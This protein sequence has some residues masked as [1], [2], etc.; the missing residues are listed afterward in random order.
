MLFRSHLEELFVDESYT[1]GKRQQIGT[2]GTGDG[3]YLAHLHLEI[4]KENMA[5]YP[6]DYWPSAEGKD[7]EW[8]MEHYL[9]PTFFIKKH[10][11][12]PVPST[13]QHCLVVYKS[14]YRLEHWQLGDRVNTYSIALSQAPLGHKQKEGDLRLP[15][16][17]YHIN[18]KSRGPFEG[19]F[20]AFFGPAWMRLSYP[21]LW[22]AK[23]GLAKGTISQAAADKIEAA[24]KAGKKP[25]K[26]TAL[27]GGSGNHGWAGD[28]QEKERH[29][30]W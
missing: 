17:A 26:N 22:D 18:Q 6:V 11:R 30:T 15:E 5:D 3:A 21:N 2:I 27:G 9:A 8:L 12:L 16:G 1:V 14:D 13:A 28:W 4:R 29:L 7:R 24:W 23:A 25:A 10:R 19:T 20:G